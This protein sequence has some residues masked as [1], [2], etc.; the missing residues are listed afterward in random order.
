LNTTEID[1]RYHLN[2]LFVFFISFNPIF[3]YG[4]AKDISST[5]YSPVEGNIFFPD[6][7]IS[8][9]VKWNKKILNKDAKL[10]YQVSDYHDEI[11]ISGEISLKDLPEGEYTVSCGKIG[12]KGFF[13][14]KYS[15]TEANI[16]GESSFCIV[17][18]PLP[19]DKNKGSLFATCY[20]YPSRTEAAARIG[21]KWAQ[22]Y[23]LWKNVEKKT[24][25][26]DFRQAEQEIDNLIALDINPLGRL[27]TTPAWAGEIPKENTLPA[28][29]AID[30]YG[31]FVHKTVSYF[32]NKIKY[33]LG[34][35]GEMDLARR[36]I[37]EETKLP[38]K[39]I[40]ER[41][42]KIARTGYEEAKKADPDCIY[43]ALTQPSGCDCQQGFPYSISLLG[44]GGQYTDAFIFD[45]YS[46][47]RNLENGLPVE[48]PERGN[49]AGCIANALIVGKNKI[50]WIA[51]YGYA[52]SLN[53]KLNSPSAKKQADYL[54]RAYIIAAS[55][56]QIKFLQWFS[57]WPCVESK[58]FSYDLW[59]W[60]APLPAV[61]VYSALGQFLTG[62]RN[63]R[64]ITMPFFIKAYAF[65]KNNGSI[66]AVWTPEDEKFNL[67]LR[68]MEGIS[69][70]DTMGN[71]IENEKKILS[72]S[73]SPVFISAPNMAVDKLCGLFAETNLNSATYVDIDAKIENDKTVLVYLQNKGCTPVDGTV[74]VIMRNEG[75][76]ANFTKLMP[77][78]TRPMKVEFVNFFSVEKKIMAEVRIKDKIYTKSIP[79]AL[80]TCWKRTDNI[81]VDGDL[82]EWKD[83]KPLTLYDTATLYPPDAESHKLWQGK[84]DLSSDAYIAWDEKYFYFAIKVND[85]IHENKNDLPFMWAAD[86]VQIAFDP[87]NDALPWN[88]SGYRKDDCEYTFCL[89][90]RFQKACIF[91]SLARD[92]R[93]PS[94]TR[95]RLAARKTEKSISYELAIP[96]DE[97]GIVPQSGKVCGFSFAILDSDG[98]NHVDYWMALSPGIAG[99]KNPSEFKKIILKTD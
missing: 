9:L 81:A 44:Q 77:K 11:L 50:C 27:T 61:A 85:D 63:P 51:E 66:A 6:E 91:K 21:V 73:G 5:V 30:N 94:V 38:E 52:L 24:G 3:A 41:I 80:L 22:A 29:S 72:I 26:F 37:A 74:T 13:S 99:G 59:R 39:V 71:E 16:D 75:S 18:K 65:E 70:F 98:G 64:E 12:K 57:M 19:F 40:N 42:I 14:I 83:R 32:K 33:W 79:V 8:F 48:S 2:V 67:E 86:C 84:N 20:L 89:S 54:A 45:P 90:T 95:A 49:F 97:L 55:F 31:K 47:Q 96:F 58:K 62:V 56:P 35:G 60:P 87:M 69:I 43:Q 34:W 92:S 15:V 17:D 4:A 10:R 76:S 53:E 78:E 23:C 25:L 36:H 88:P 68:N 46:N 1:M 82:S 93:T 28:D 7:E